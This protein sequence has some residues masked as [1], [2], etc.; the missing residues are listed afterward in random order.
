MLTAV[1]CQQCHLQGQSR[2]LRR[3]RK[4]FDFRPGLPYELFW[5]VFV[6]SGAGTDG[7]AVGQV[8]QMYVSRCFRASDGKLGCISCHNP[9]E[10]PAPARKIAFYRG[11]CLTCHGEKGCSLPLTTRLEQSKEDSCI[12]CHMPRLHGSDVAHTAMTDHRVPRRPSAA[13][14]PVDGAGRTM[15][16][17][18]PTVHFHA[19]SAKK[20][21]I[22]V[23]REKALML[24]EVAHLPIP[25]RQ[26]LGRMAL[27]LL[28]TATKQAPDDLLALEGKAYALWLR[29]RNQEALALYETILARVPRREISLVDAATLA[30]QLD[31]H[32]QARAYWERAV[33]VNPVYSQYHFELARLLARHGDWEKARDECQATLRLDLANEEARKLLIRGYL[34]TTSPDKA[35][36]ELDVLLALFP[37]RQDE[38]RRW[39]AEQAP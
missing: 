28:E 20:L 38:L 31:R 22:D 26:R 36:A 17:E 5:T 4:P 2:I 21:G 9:H 11:R 13:A 34:H 35:R 25:D 15:R 30:E 3:G 12:Q 19:S 33:A 29:S 7:K 1:V 32:D 27:P 8:E 24:I 10:T 6:S 14:A 39:F 18:L 37:G 16:G 23:G